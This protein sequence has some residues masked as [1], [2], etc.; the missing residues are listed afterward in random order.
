M[1][2]ARTFRR[3]SSDERWDLTEIKEME[4]TPW[5]PYPGDNRY[6]FKDIRPNAKFSDEPAIPAEDEAAEKQ[7]RLPR[8]QINKA[9]LRKH[10]KTHDCAGCTS[11]ERGKQ[12]HHSKSCIT[13][14][15]TLTNF[16]SS[17]RRTSYESSPRWTGLRGKQASSPYI[18]LQAS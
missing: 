1:V 18:N 16:L 9:D 5:H 10:L 8:F 14:W 4:G 3:K 13:L 7:E 11:L 6:T 2:K 17:N 15:L 12:G